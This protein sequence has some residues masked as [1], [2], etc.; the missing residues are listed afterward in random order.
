MPKKHR[1]RII[2]F[3]DTLNF[4]RP[5]SFIINNMIILNASFLVPLIGL[6]L[7]A[8]HENRGHHEKFS[9]F[10]RGYLPSF[11]I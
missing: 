8:C 9:F 11:P 7:A 1:F 4:S 10:R 5:I 3:R 2:Y 6:I